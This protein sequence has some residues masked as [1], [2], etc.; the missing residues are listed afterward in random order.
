[1]TPVFAQFSQSE[2]VLA[3]FEPSTWDHSF[4][5]LHSTSVT[6]EDSQTFRPVEDQTFGQPVIQTVQVKDEKTFGA[7]EVVTVKP[8]KEQISVAAKENSDRLL[9]QAAVNFEKKECSREEEEQPC[10]AE[11]RME[12]EA[13]ICPEVRDLISRVEQEQQPADF[14]QRAVLSG[15]SF[16]YI[17]IIMI[18]IHL[19]HNVD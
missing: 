1:M 5:L 17:I 11:E 3:F 12:I 4:R 10:G 7:E 9:H 6:A 18:I 15:W 2:A 8:N 13:D 16:S 19:H 14:L